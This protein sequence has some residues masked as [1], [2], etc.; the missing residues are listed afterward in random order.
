MPS[1]SPVSAAVAA[2]AA[3]IRSGKLPPGSLLPTHRQLAARHG[4]AL[5]SASKVYA[6]LQAMGLVVGEIG[7]G[8][9]VRDR[10]QQREWDSGDEARL[11]SA[12]ADLSFNH[13]SPPGQA[14]LLRAMLRELAASGDLATLMH[15]QPPGG[16]MRERQTVADFLAGTRGMEVT[17]DHLFLVNGAQQGLDIAVRALLKRHD[18]VAVDALSYPGFRMLAELQELRLEPVPALADGPD[19]NAL[20]SLCRKHHIRAIY[21]MPTLHNPLGWILDLEQRQRLVETA[22]RYDCLL[23]EDASY[24]YLPEDAPPALATLAPERTVHVSSLSKSLASG[25]RFGYLLAPAYCAARIKAAIRASYWSLPSLITAMAS[26]W[27]ADGT[28]VR[29]EAVLRREAR[30]RQAIARRVFAGMEMVANPASLFI[31]L[32]LPEEL[33]M[34]RI[35]TALAERDIAVSKAEAYATTRHAPHALRLGLSSVPLEQLEG[36]LLRLRETLERFPP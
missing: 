4:M 28:V 11:S 14:E 6:Q 17:A 29:Q 23:I 35:A 2:L 8:T 33:R 20:E 21:T 5:A 12:A 26:R 34:D 25:L 18:T 7:R 22:R 32:P 27:M 36:V 13:P 16:R 9:F 31:W 30:A 15:Q 1:P 19:L 10:A 24:A 3:D